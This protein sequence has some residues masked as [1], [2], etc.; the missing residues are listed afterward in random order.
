M[1]SKQAF[2]SR[3]LVLLLAAGLLTGVVLLLSDMEDTVD[4]EK[5]NSADLLPL[6]TVEEVQAGAGS[7][8]VEAFGEIRPR[9][10]ADLKSEVSG[11]VVKVHP[12]A[13][14]G[15]QVTEGESLFVIEDSQHQA[16]LAE[17]ELR[18]QEAELA[19]QQ[20]LYATRVAERQF[21]SAGEQPPNDLA[22]HLPQLHIAN[23][24]VKAARARVK[25]AKRQLDQTRIQAPYSG[26]LVECYVSLG[27]MLMAGEPVVRL[28]DD[29]HFDVRVHLSHEDW[30]RL[31]K[32]VQGQE[33]SLHNGQGDVLGSAVVREGGGYLDE[34]TRHYILHLYARQA[35]TRVLAG[36]LVRVR[37]QGRTEHNVLSV[38]ASALTADGSIW[39]VEA[40]G[41]LASALVEVLLHDDD[42][43]LVRAPADK[44]Q[45]QILVSPLSSYLPGQRVR[46]TTDEAR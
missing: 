13:L 31:Q 27:Q 44:A 18:L 3:A 36:E 8:S 15:R 26:Y 30:R 1:S 33:V 28:I 25:V 39:W 20:A 14:A 42:R 38:P 5:Q 43:V 40:D 9:W 6:V 46:A 2:R 37:F 10:A 24:S 12:G 41:T 19:Q 11:V 45:W 32:P 35:E 29:R 22:L 4:I 23:A 16:E 21:E 17:A 7:V 34:Q